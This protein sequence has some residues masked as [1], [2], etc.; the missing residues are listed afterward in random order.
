VAALAWPLLQGYHAAIRHEWLTAFVAFGISLPVL[1]LVLAICKN[2]YGMVTTRCTWDS[3]GTT[4]W[5]DREF[6]R[7]FLVAIV[8]LI[9]AGVLFVVLMPLGVLDLPA[10]RGLQAVTGPLL[11]GSATVA[12]VVG[13]VV[14]SGTSCGRRGSVR[15]G[16]VVAEVLGDRLPAAGMATCG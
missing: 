10:D 6:T 14:K 1:T 2:M 11:I 16:A 8:F 5:P 9:P 7:A 3:T 12:A 13:V 15:G 4:F